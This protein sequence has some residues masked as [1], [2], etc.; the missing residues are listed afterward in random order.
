MSNEDTNDTAHKVT[1]NAIKSR[2][3]RRPF[4]QHSLPA[5]QSRASPTCLW[6]GR[7]PHA[8]RRDCPAANDTCHRCGKRG[9]WQQVCRASAANTMHQADT[10]FQS[11]TAYVITHDIAQVQSSMGILNYDVDT[12]NQLHVTSTPSLPPLG[13]LTFDS[14]KVNYPH[15]FEGLG[16]LGEPYSL[17]LDPTIKPIQAAPHRYAAPKLPIIKEALDKLIDTGQ[18]V[19]VNEPTLWIS[20]MVVRE[21]PPSATKPAKVRICLDPSQTINKAIL[22]PVYPIPTLERFHQA[23][24][25][26]TFDIKD[27]FQTIKLTEESSKLTTMH[28]PWGRYRWTRLPFGISSAP[29]EFQRRIHDVLCG[30]EGVVNIADDIIVIG[31]GTSLKEATHD[32]DRTVIELL[33]RLS[34]HHLKLN[35]D[36]VKLKTCSAPFMGHTLTPEGLK[37]SNEIANAVL[38]MPQPQDKAATRRFLG[39]ITYLSKFCPRLSEVVRPLRDLTHIDQKFLWADQHTEA[40]RQAK[41][42]VSQA[43]CLRYFDVKAPVVLQ[44]DASEYG[45]G[46]ALLQPATCSLNSSDTLWQPVAYSSSSLSQ[47]EQRYAQIEK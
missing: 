16:E 23:K 32:H 33:D 35:P 19:R 21:R 4:K 45:L 22:R 38:N 37:P 17:T 31:R 12:V 6:C 5:S 41:E 20:N 42:L 1:P 7:T 34:Q 3:P 18:L 25:F 15:L 36:K 2:T 9:H 26:S 30:L 46:A 13:E 8:A 39:T 43:P 24:I 11:S 47:T 28:T 10:G 14:I 44:V 29:E 40:L 27:A